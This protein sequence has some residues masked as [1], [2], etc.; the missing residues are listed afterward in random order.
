[1]GFVANFMRFPEC[2]NFE[3]RLRFGKV[4]ELRIFLRHSVNPMKPKP[5]LGAF[6][7]SGQQTDGSIL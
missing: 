3:N 5:G 2:K 4:T 6:Y 1:M 7:A